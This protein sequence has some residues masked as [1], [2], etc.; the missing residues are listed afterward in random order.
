MDE[1]TP[2]P[3]A[4]AEAR[5][6]Y[7]MVAA[8]ATLPEIAAG[9]GRDLTPDERRMANRA[10]LAKKV[11][12]AQGFMPAPTAPPASPDNPFAPFTPAPPSPPV[13][14]RRVHVGQEGK[15][16]KLVRFVEEF[17]RDF[18]AKQAA[19]RAGWSES[20]ATQYASRLLKRRKVQAM[21]AETREAARSKA[22]LGLQEAMEILTAIARANLK[23]YLTEHGDID[24]ANLRNKAGPALAELV[25][26][27][28]EGKVA[29]KLRDPI[30]AI[31]RIAKLMGWDKPQ[32]VNLRGAVVV[33]TP[34]LTRAP[35][36]AAE[37]PPGE[38]A[39]DAA[40]D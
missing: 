10:R 22:V 8:G 18:N 16:A 4:N 29:L 14:I 12:K 25:K 21:L 23:D 2:M 17:L 37:L 6:I 32:E 24:M 33:V 31:E 40:A 38:G 35:A 5:R 27:Y 20:W 13:H 1:T 3:A 30:S 19:I 28:K 15:H 39:N 26:N 34:T 36:P 7:A 9:L 11:R